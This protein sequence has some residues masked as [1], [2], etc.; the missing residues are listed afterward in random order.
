[1]LNWCSTWQL[2]VANH[3]C[4]S[5]YF[6]NSNSKHSYS[7]GQTSLLEVHSV[8]DLG[9]AI[10]NNHQFN[11]HMCTVF[12]S[13]AWKMHILLR[14]IHLRD[15]AILVHCFKTWVLPK[16]EF[17]SSVWSPFK[18]KDIRKIERVQ[19]S[20][21]RIVY[22]KCFGVRCYT[23]LPN[24]SERLNRLGLVTLQ[25]RRVR[26]DLV[27]AFKILNGEVRLSRSRYFR[28]KL[29]NGRTKLL[30]FH[31]P[32]T[33]CNAFKNSFFIRAANWLMKLPSNVLKSRTSNH[34][35]A[36]LEDIDLVNLFQLPSVT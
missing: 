10:Q 30:N 12:N 36:A 29:T 1:M 31:I 14:I 4:H 35:Q 25:E 2:E 15:P 19:S 20:F 11:E 16:L 3:K 9:V 27:L 6:G 26:K 34:F 8:R 13:A 18:M 22:F 28:P 17:S 7:I 32:F 5:L 23:D 33:K 21:T 24:Y